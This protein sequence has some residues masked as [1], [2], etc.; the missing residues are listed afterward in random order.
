MSGQGKKRTYRR[1]KVT[2]QKAM[3][4]YAKAGSIRGAAALLGVSHWTVD[5]YLRMAGFTP[6]SRYAAGH[7]RYMPSRHW[8]RVGQWFR[9][10]QD[11]RFPRSVKAIA[12]LIGVSRDSVKCYLYRRREYERKKALM[13]PDIRNLKGYIAVGDRMIFPRQIECYELEVDPW[14]FHY[15]V[16]AQLTS[17]ETVRFTMRKELLCGSAK[18]APERDA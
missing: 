9:R 18:S 6:K 13:A 12:F 15:H 8:S 4:A 16:K 3:K 7:D 11:K 5:H 2:P 17:G 10:H 14:T 1:G